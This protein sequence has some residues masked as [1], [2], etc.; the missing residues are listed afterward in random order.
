MEDESVSQEIVWVK[1]GVG[2]SEE[3]RKEVDGIGQIE[4]ETHKFVKWSL[5]LLDNPLGR[6]LGVAYERG[7]DN[8]DKVGDSGPSGRSIRDGDDLLTEF[9]KIVI[10]LVV[11][12]GFRSRGDRG[13]PGGG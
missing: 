6:I 11:G 4:E 13:G 9:P 7:R 1:C 5:V 8:S 10:V 12:L 2:R 3:S